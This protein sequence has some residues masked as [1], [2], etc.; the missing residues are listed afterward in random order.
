MAF[1][2][3][4]DK[5]HFNLDGIKNIIVAIKAS[6]NKGL[7]NELKA[8]FTDV[9]P[10]T[11]PLVSN[12]KINENWLARFINGEGCFFIETRDSITHKLGKQVTLKMMVTQHTRD[13][14][15]LKSIPSILNCGKYYERLNR[16]EC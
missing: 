5:K 2:L 11:R 3:V 6:M 4:K 7:S 15:I 1:Y 16:N 8:A 9:T 14:E 12:Q 13:S 10:V